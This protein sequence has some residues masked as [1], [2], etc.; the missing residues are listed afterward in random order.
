MLERLAAKRVP[1]SPWSAGLLGPAA[2]HL[3]LGAAAIGGLNPTEVHD[4]CGG[5]AT[6]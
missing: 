6:D 1:S 3:V 4:S 2:S 5:S